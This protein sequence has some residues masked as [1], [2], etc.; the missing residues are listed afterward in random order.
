MS[1]TSYRAAPPRVIRV[2]PE[3]KSRYHVFALANTDR[4]N[5]LCLRLYPV[6]TEGKL[7]YELSAFYK[8]SK[9][10]CVAALWYRQGRLIEEK[11]VYLQHC[12]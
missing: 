9:A 3:A 2:L 7:P 10:A 5:T 12:A 6:F 8:C 1:L 11:I 4:A